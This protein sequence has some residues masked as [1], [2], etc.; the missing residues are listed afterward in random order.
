MTIITHFLWAHLN[1]CDVLEEILVFKTGGKRMLFTVGF[2]F[3]AVLKV[4][5]VSMLFWFCPMTITVSTRFSIFQW[6]LLILVDLHPFLPKL[7]QFPQFLQFS[8]FTLIYFCLSF[9]SC[10]QFATCSTQLMGLSLRCSDISTQLPPKLSPQQKP[11]LPP[12]SPL[13]IVHL[14]MFNWNFGIFG[15]LTSVV[16]ALEMKPLKEI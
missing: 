10:Y 8:Y 3:W 14:Q 9:L 11:F 1:Y 6:A 5:W 2:I 12:P 13:L 4:L 7:F 16:T 15:Y